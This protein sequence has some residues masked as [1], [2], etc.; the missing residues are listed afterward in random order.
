MDQV[1]GQSTFLKRQEFVEPAMHPLVVIIAMEQHQHAVVDGSYRLASLVEHQ[2]I[3]MALPG[4][5]NSSADRSLR[6]G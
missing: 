5:A 1:V 6:S 2:D 4:N 3:A